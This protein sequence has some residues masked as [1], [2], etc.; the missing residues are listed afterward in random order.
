MVVTCE[1]ATLAFEECAVR[2]L[3]GKPDDFFDHINAYYSLYI[4]V[5]YIHWI[6]A[7]TLLKK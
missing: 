2:I 3:I 4:Y 6:I 5:A 1:G 7:H